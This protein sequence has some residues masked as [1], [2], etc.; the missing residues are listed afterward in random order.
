M[1]SR[2]VPTNTSDEA[3]LRYGIDIY[4]DC[5]TC[6]PIYTCPNCGMAFVPSIWIEINGHLRPICPYCGDP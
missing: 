3:S 5:C 2:I 1:T 4:S 6:P